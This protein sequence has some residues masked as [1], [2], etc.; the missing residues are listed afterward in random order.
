MTIATT[1]KIY[2]EQQSA[3]YEIISHQRTQ[4]SMDTATTAHIPV[5]QLAK[6]VIVKEEEV[7]LMVVVPSDYHVHLGR[8]HQHLEHEVGLATEE[9]LIAL[10]PDCD[11]GAIPPVGMAYDIRTLVDTSLRQQDDIFFES[12]DHQHLIKVTGE[13]F[14]LLFGDAESINV[15]KHM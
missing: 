5:D 10:F 14:A 7:Y 12:G 13:Q 11:S 2:L 8:L 1:L 15:A 9:E 4:T 3:V 6:A